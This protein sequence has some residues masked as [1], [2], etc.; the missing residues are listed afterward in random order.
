[1]SEIKVIKLITSEEILGE[2]VSSNIDTITVNRP[3]VIQVMNTQGAAGLMPYLVSDPDI[4]NV[5]FPRAHIITSFDASKEL[6]DAYL[7]A[8]TGLLLG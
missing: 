6:T 1:M 3:R 8:T 2:F 7:R 5:S 4:K